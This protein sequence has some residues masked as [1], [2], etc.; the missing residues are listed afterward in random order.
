MLETRPL[1]TRWQSD[2]A[3][4]MQLGL[5][6]TND[7]NYTFGQYTGLQDDGATLIGNLRWQ[8]FRSGEEYWQVS[9]SDLGLDTR[10]GHLTWGRTDR[11]RVQLG[12]DSQ[13]QVRNDSGRTPFSGEDKQTLPGNWVSGQNT[14]DF[15]NLNA[16]LRGFD[17]E[18]DRDKLSMAFDARLND[19][20]RLDSNLS[21]EEK[22]G[23]GD[24]GTG[25]Y[26]NG[27]AADAVL[28]RSPIDYST[29]EFDLGLAYDEGQLHL[30]GQLAYSIFDN[31]D[32]RP[33]LAK[34]LQLLR[35]ESALP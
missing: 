16:S 34:P 5:G 12:F 15:A 3:G 7:D 10:E 28:L 26:I 21:Y 9:M 19:N 13:Q 23:N 6:F 22:E 8:D 29:T 30:N 18:L 2:Y 27:A 33:H 31:D 17:R 32:D 11:L 25:I 1:A 14:T 4:A 20:W 35:L 24:V